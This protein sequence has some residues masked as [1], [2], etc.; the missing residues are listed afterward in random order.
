MGAGWQLYARRTTSGLWLHTDVPARFAFTWTMSGPGAA[1]GIVP[2]AYDLAD[3]GDGLPLWLERGT[4]LYAERDQ[5]LEW[6]GLCSYQRDTAA[7]RQVEFKGLSSALD[8]IAYDGAY[9]RWEADPFAVVEELVGN[10]AAQPDGDVGLQV[11][12]DGR[13]PDTVGDPKPPPA[14]VKPKRRKGET[15]DAYDDRLFEWEKAYDD[16][17]RKYGDREPYSI[18][19]WDH[20]YIGPELA[21]LGQEAGFEWHERHGWTDR[22]TLTAHHDLVVHPPRST[23][24]TEVAFVEGENI[25]DVIEPTTSLDRY[26]NHVVA[27]GAGE[28]RDMKRATY[29]HRDNRV[30][31]TRFL[32]S[33]NVRNVKRLRRKAQR[34]YGQADVRTTLEGLEVHDSAVAGVRVGDEVMVRSRV[35]EGWC[36]ITNITRDTDASPASLTFDVGEG[37]Q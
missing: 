14:P 16:W 33:K 21:E 5:Q 20:E 12:R 13:A 1:V 19:W 34:A 18:A 2:A 8:L 24:R 22:D 32:E 36:R 7:G 17:E 26:G 23:R 10:A 30:R 28:G 15:R 11:V 29:G 37:A 27:L 25:A 35:F 3:A 31:T 9:R 6:V 4:T